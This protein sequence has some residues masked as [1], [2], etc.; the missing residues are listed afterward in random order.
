MVLYF[1]LLFFVTMILSIVFM[2]D[3]SMYFKHVFNYI[4]C[5]AFSLEKGSIDFF[6][7]INKNKNN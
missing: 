3:F 2:Y 5:Q 1:N 7:K 6:K 4:E